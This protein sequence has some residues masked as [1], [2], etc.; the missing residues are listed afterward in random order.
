MRKENITQPF[1][2]LPSAT[3]RPEDAPLQADDK[4]DTE[5]MDNCR[6]IVED[7]SKPVKNG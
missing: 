7:F 2:F 6:C 4:L 3:R 5:S 1:F